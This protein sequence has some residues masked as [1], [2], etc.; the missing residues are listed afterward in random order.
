MPR[1]ILRQ[2]GQKM[3]AVSDAEWDT[4]WP[5]A[6]DAEPDRKC[7]QYLMQ[8]NGTSANTAATSRPKL[9]GGV[10]LVSCEKYL[11]QANRACPGRWRPGVAAL[12][13]RQPAIKGGPRQTSYYCLNLIS[14]KN[15][16]YYIIDHEY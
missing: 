16:S 11:G 9:V 2:V 7:S 14:H 1:S 12:V 10:V 15:L 13:G 8:K 4:K 6:S 3:P 5:A